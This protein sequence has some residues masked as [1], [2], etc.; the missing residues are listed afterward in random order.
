M[1]PLIRLF[2]SLYL[3]LSKPR[4]YEETGEVKDEQINEAEF[5]LEN[6]TKIT[7]RFYKKV[8]VTYTYSFSRMKSK[9][10]VLYSIKAEFDPPLEEKN[11]LTTLRVF[12]TKSPWLSTTDTNITRGLM[13]IYLDYLFSKNRQI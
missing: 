2:V 6:G 12:L 7:F 1:D 8:M 11:T 4:L 9:K 10:S 5:Q 13:N 3:R